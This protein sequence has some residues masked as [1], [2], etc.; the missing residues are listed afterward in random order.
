MSE[1]RL[2]GIF[3]IGKELCLTVH[4]QYLQWT[5]AWHSQFCIS[6]IVFCGAWV[7]CQF[8]HGVLLPLRIQ[9]S[10]LIWP[11]SVDEK[12]QVINFIE[13]TNANGEQCN[14]ISDPP[15]LQHNLFWFMFVV[16]GWLV[17][18]RTSGRVRFANNNEIKCDDGKYRHSFICFCDF[19]SAWMISNGSLI[20][21][22]SL[23]TIV[24]AVN[25][26]CN[27]MVCHSFFNV[28]LA[29]SNRSPGVAMHTFISNFYES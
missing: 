28:R 29:A 18:I 12:R 1:L 24:S 5:A 26:N 10:I 14:E 9:M 22:K 19:A 21:I 25:Y 17:T 20:I 23:A 15:F 4:V 13:I 27:N 7:T 16:T 2:T 6:C 11:F 3:R 8:G